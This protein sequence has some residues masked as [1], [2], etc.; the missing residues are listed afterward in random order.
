VRDYFIKYCEQFRNINEFK[1][2][3]SYWSTQSTP[4]PYCK[5]CPTGYYSGYPLSGTTIQGG[6][7]MVTSKCYLISSSA[8]TVNY[9][10]A[11]TTCTTAQAGPATGGYFAAGI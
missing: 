5:L 8:T 6:Y 2:F 3:L 11:K 1:F 4:S 10:T 9:A 7:N